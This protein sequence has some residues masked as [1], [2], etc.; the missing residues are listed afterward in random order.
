MWKVPRRRK[1]PGFWR[2]RAMRNRCTRCSLPLFARLPRGRLHRRGRRRGFAADDERLRANGASLVP[3]HLACDE[4]ARRRFDDRCRHPQPGSPGDS[5]SSKL[6]AFQ[7]PVPAL[8]VRLRQRVTRRTTN[9]SDPSIREPVCKFPGDAARARV[10]EQ[11]RSV[12][13][14]RRSCRVRSSWCTASRRRR[15]GQCR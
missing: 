3:V 10:R 13:H 14:A 4:A 5:F 9:A 12:T 8:D 2:Q 1:K 7:R 11:P 6:E 15:G